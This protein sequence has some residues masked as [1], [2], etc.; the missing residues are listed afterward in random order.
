MAPQVSNL[1][2][3]IMQLKL[4]MDRVKYRGDVDFIKI[5]KSRPHACASVIHVTYSIIRDNNFL[6][7]QL[8]LL[9][10]KDVKNIKRK[11]V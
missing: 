3:N 4:K 5:F 1:M 7:S 6:F 8:K 2:L 9:R 11:N 10:A